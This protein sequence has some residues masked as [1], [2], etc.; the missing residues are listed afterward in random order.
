MTRRLPPHEQDAA[1][2]ALGGYEDGS[3]HDY[4]WMGKKSVFRWPLDIP[5]SIPSIFNLT[6]YLCCCVERLSS[7]SSFPEGKHDILGPCNFRCSTGNR[8][9]QNSPS[10]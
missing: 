1:L 5:L 6:D 9:G 3:G 4:D 7:L 10:Q 8:Y 2:D